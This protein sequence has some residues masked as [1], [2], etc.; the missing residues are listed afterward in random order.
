ML[1]LFGSQIKAFPPLPESI[2]VLS[3][4]TNENIKWSMQEIAALPLPNLE[5]LKV[6]SCPLIQNEHVLAILAPSLEKRSLRSLSLPG[7]H[8][9]DFHS[10]DWLLRHGENLEKLVIVANSCAVTDEA[11]KEVMKFKMLRYLDLSGCDISLIGLM[12]V[13]NGS[14]GALRE[15]V[16]S[17]RLAKDTAVTQLAAK[18]GV[19]ITSR[20]G[21]L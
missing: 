11:L 3:L 18:S 14:L 8:S 17:C 19:K 1:C 9:L 6:G 2:R 10:F 5:T 20:L 15:V 13:V 4:D 12:N 7:C 21:Y 16:I